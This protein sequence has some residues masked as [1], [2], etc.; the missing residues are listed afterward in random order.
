MSARWEEAHEDGTS[1][2]IVEDGEGYAVIVDGS[3]M[4][5]VMEYGSALVYAHGILG[6]QGFRGET[7]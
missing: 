2:A 5:W 3:E 6:G 4:L 7:V 1:I